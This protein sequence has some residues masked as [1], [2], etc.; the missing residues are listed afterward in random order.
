VPH[1]TLSTA[2]VARILGLE[3]RR[4][5]ELVRAGLL[6]PSRR[7]RRYAFSFQD[8]VVLRAA[9]GLFDARVPATR[10]RRALQ[11]LAAQLPP[12][13]PL[14]GLRIYAD[15]RHVA[16]CDGEAS[17][18][19]DTG[20][21]LLDF[22]V[23]AL[24]RAAAGVRSAVR[25]PQ[26]AAHAASADRATRARAEFERALDLE[27][28]DP[29]AAVEAYQRAVELDPQQAD[30]W[31]NLGR[32]AH[33]AGRAREAVR[34]YERALA[35]CPDD[36]V[37]HYNLALALEDVR[38]A[39]AAAAHYEKALALDPDFAD[40]HYNLAGLCEQLGREAAALRHYHAYKKLTDD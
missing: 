24:A 32:L 33:E 11:A 13:R 25:Q 26:P 14:S 10:V 36:P 22:E 2:E 1:G 40:A 4:I 18:R 29:A 17:W 27:D 8:L 9:K 15:G 12:E 39:A 37:I 38:G 20:Q 3:E 19:P 5:R 16:V 7:G 6:Q 23:D 30:A 28:V 34:L 35:L 31:V 21:T